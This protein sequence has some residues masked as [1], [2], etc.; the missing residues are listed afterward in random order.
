MEPCIYC[1]T[2][3]PW[4]VVLHHSQR[5]CDAIL[6][7]RYRETY[8]SDSYTPADMARLMPGAELI[9]RKA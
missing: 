8:G 3:V 6:A 1:D 5:E 4:P 9:E 7:K 2:L